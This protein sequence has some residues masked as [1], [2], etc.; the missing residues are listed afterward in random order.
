MPRMSIY[1]PDDLAEQLKDADPTR[2]ASQV[3]QE[4]LRR[5]LGA[6]STAA[7]YARVP[8]NAVQ[9]VEQ[10]RSQLM[11]K[12]QAD[13]E[14]GYAAALGRVEDLPWSALDGLA[15]AHFDVAA[16]IRPWTNGAGDI[17]AGR[18]PEDAESPNWL[19]LLAQDLGQLA[20]PIGVDKF[21]FRP[22]DMYLRGYG[23]G[24]RVAFDAVLRHPGDEGGS[25][26]GSSEVVTDT[27]D[28][29]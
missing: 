7:A 23:D 21:S 6:S 20:D 25:W 22:S 9:L 28:A 18:G 10:A 8:S 17:A 19:P 27:A 1:L 13:Y 5:Y 26:P 15:G 3:I 11:P 2:S 29:S 14:R 24:L 4:A 16:W 12:A